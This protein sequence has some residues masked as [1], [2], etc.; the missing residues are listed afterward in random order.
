VNLDALKYITTSTENLYKFLFIN[1]TVYLVISL[2][3]PLQKRD[4]LMLKVIDYN[5]K[6]ELL[7]FEIEK[8]KSDVDQFKL[9][10]NLMVSEIDSLKLTGK[11]NLSL[12][13]VKQKEYNDKFDLLEQRKDDLK[14]KNISLEASNEKIKEL[15][16]Q[17]E[18][19]KTYTLWLS[20]S[21]VVCLVFGFLGWFKNTRTMAEINEETLKKVKADNA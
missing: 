10:S 6:V 19:Y 3:Y 11:K 17:S 5:E 20:I 16:R 21:G 18:T 4:E 7:N 12:T 14:R 8:V 9:F 15:K 2:F 13:K 1:G